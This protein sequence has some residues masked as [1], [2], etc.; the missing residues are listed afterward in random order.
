[1]NEWKVMRQIIK[2]AQPLYSVTCKENGTTVTDSRL[3]ASRDEAWKRLK[4]LRAMGEVARTAWRI[5]HQI[6][7]LSVALYQAC[8]KVDGVLQMD[9]NIYPTYE[10][11]QKRVNELNAKEKAPDAARATQGAKK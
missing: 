9:H 4:K 8:G 11:A 7:N 5:T 3:Y 2:P 6:V 1:M 10:K